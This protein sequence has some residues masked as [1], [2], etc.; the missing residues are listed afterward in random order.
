MQYNYIL[1]TDSRFISYSV[2][3]LK[4]RLGISGRVKTMALGRGIYLAQIEGESAAVLGKLRSLTFSYG[5]VPL[6]GL[7]EKK[8]S[9]EELNGLVQ[10][11][12]SKGEPFRIEVVSLGAKRGESAKD[13]E[14]KL[15]QA[16]EAMGF[17]V[18]LKAPKRVVYVIVGE[19]ITVI[20]SATSSDMED[21]TV[22][23]FRSE[24]KN[25]DTVNRA[26]VKMKEAFDVF[27]LNEKKIESCLDIGASPGGWTNF[28]VKRGARVV[29]IDK[30][31]L[32]YDR[33]ATKDVKVIDDLKDYSEGNAVLHIR[34]NI[35]DTEKL[36]I[37]ESSFDMLAIDT[38]TDYLE[39]SRIANS[40]SAYLKPGGFLVM[41]LKLP[42]I[43]D[44]GKIYMATQILSKSYKVE[45]I[46][47]LHYNRMELTLFATRL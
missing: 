47:K 11:C 44:A 4:E 43:S 25:Q 17:A 41:T 13:T 42:K 45:R 2:S 16:L 36:P 19:G 20:G 34:A 22:D 32:E 35:S 7:M 12:V 23:H 10:K 26:E 38:N 39:S 3:E 1:L 14:V 40:L 18:S 46:K 37:R 30:G 29:A 9:A 15:G 31:A 21:M 8:A 33:L 6:A 28:M 24:N 5:I 27:G